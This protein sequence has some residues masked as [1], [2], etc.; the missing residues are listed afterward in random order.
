MTEG[1]DFE[2]ESRT[3]G[4]PNLASQ[5]NGARHR[6]AAE[7]DGAGRRRRHSSNDVPSTSEDRTTERKRELI[8]VAG[9]LFAERGFHGTSMADIAREFGVRKA[10]LYH[11]VESKESLLAQVLADV[12]YDAAR[13][14]R[15]VV[16]LDLPAAERFRMMVRI[17]IDSWAQN[18]HNMKV[19]LS[20]GR[21]LEGEARERWIHSRVEIEEMYRQVLADGR[22][23]GEFD[24]KPR[25]LTLVL[26]SALGVMQWFPRWYE[27]EGWAT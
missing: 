15:E 13:E 18:P 19:G 16:S 12:S 5:P 3:D 2:T 21:W 24:I 26:N 6:T 17:H 20:E 8:E 9:R 4:S 10:T 22:A 25:E 11:W 1:I 27:S 14:M 7:G 23:S